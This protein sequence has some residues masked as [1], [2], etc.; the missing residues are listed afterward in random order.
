MYRRKSMIVVLAA[1]LAFSSG[2]VLCQLEQCT[3]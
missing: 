3:K 2:A 1:G